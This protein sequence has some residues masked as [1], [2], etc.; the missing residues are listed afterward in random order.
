MQTQVYLSLSLK[1]GVT[2]TFVFRKENRIGEIRELKKKSK[3]DAT[4]RKSTIGVH[5]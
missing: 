2:L 4:W 3:I 1:V 5:Y